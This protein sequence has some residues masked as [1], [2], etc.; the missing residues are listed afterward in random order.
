MVPLLMSE[1][2]FDY[3]LGGSQRISTSS[4]SEFHV[5]DAL[6]K[7]ESQNTYN[8]S[9]LQTLLTPSEHLHF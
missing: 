5:L 7:E 8:Q 2:D 6:T 9:F 4:P 1:D 3:P